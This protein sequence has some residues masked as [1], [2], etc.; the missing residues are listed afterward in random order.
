MEKPNYRKKQEDAE[1]KRNEA[2]EQTDREEIIIALNGVRDDLS[3]EREKSKAKQ[4]R[5]HRIERLKFR[6]E[7]SKFYLDLTAVIGA[8]VAA[9]LLFIQSGIFLVT[10]LDARH[11]AKK[12]HADNV[13]ALNAADR[14]W[15][16][17]DSLSVDF[18]I[19]KPEMISI[20]MKNTGHSPALQTHAWFQE[21]VDPAPGQPCPTKWVG[22]HTPPTFSVVIFPNQTVVAKLEVIPK[23]DQASVNLFVN[24]ICIL[25]VA[26]RIEY[27][28]SGR[29]PH[30]TTVRLTYEAATGIFSA[31]PSGN[32]AD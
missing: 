6:R 20:S 4:R 25:R 1:K 8:I 23:V 15:V 19:G 5:D 14:P 2:Q 11:A 22:F 10:M 26:G 12:A 9:T 32:D 24:T 3:A 13:A 21:F 27:V 17:V 31:D 29:A 30:F 7:R 16:G 18:T 28:D